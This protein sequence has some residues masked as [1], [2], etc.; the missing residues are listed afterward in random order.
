MKGKEKG[1]DHSGWASAEMRVRDSGLGQTGQTLEQAVPREA[2]AGLP[3]SATRVIRFYG[4]V[5]VAMP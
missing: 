4:L 2:M 1:G 5:C 3:A